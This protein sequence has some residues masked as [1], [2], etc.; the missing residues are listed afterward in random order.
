MTASMR[1]GII[2]QHAPTGPPGRLGEWAQARG[3]PYEVHRSWETPP[4]LDP[5]EYGFIAS[6]GSAHSANDIEVEWV[7][8]EIAL[9]RRA[10]E[11]DVPVLGL[12]WGGQALSAALDGTVG[13]APFHEK[14]WV[15]VASADPEIPGGPW[16]HYHTEIFTVPRGAA[17]L[18]RSPAGPAAFRLGPHLGL[19]FHPE[20][21]ADTAHVW[22]A[23]DPAQT[24]QTRERLVAAGERWDAPA[25]ELAMALFDAWWARAGSLASRSAIRA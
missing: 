25:R 22:A 1:P 4:E 6:L 15:A 16:L 20:A 14:D 19:Q 2:L 7:A 23:K 13:P 11:E 12:C 8:A 10:V 24:E 5:R 9:L 3:I 17:E 21:D 18:A